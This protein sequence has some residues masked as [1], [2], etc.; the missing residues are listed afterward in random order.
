MQYAKMSIRVELSS[1]EPDDGGSQRKL[2]GGPGIAALTGMEWM[3]IGD[4]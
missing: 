4:D 2:L 1:L 3:K